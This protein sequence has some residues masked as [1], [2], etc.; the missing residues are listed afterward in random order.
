MAFDPSYPEDFKKALSNTISDKEIDQFLKRG[1]SPRFVYGVLMLPTVL[2]Y[3]IDGDQGVKIHK[4]MT[5]ATLPGYQLYE[6]ANSSAPVIARSNNP[7]ANVKGML[8]FNLSDEERN[9]IYEFES[10]LM[11]LSSVEVDIIQ[12]SYLGNVHDMRRIDAGAFVWDESVHLTSPMIG[13]KVTRGTKWDLVPYLQGRFYR[14]IKASQCR[15]V[16]EKKV[17][18]SQTEQSTKAQKDGPTSCGSL[19]MA[20][21]VSA[22]ELIDDEEDSSEYSSA[23]SEIFMYS[24]D[25]REANS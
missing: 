8:V 7:Q 6:F 21:K 12:K 24:L 20:T 14:D 22:N 9:S 11:R 19:T 15:G 3:Y 25:E 5:Q 10:G 13:L 18:E 2:K 4:Q 17:M 23:N 1:G 16:L